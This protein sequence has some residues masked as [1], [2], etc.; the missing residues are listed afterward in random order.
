MNPALPGERLP[1]TSCPGGGAGPGTLRHLPAAPGTPG[2]LTRFSAPGKAPQSAE[3]ETPGSKRERT[4]AE[5]PARF[6][7]P[8]HGQTPPSAAGTARTTTPRGHR[9]CVPNR[10]PNG[11]GPTKRGPGKPLQAQAEGLAEPG[12]A[13]PRSAFPN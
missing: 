11:V 1:N 9:I 13:L 8:F 12:D 3:P 7:H 6:S 4:A 10:D 5:A 2:T